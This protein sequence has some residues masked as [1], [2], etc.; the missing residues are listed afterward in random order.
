L[1]STSKELLVRRAPCSDDEIQDSLAH[2]HGGV[3]LS[4]P[5]VMG[6]KELELDELFEIVH[7]DWRDLLEVHVR[8]SDAINWPDLS[9]SLPSLGQSSLFALGGRVH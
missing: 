3:G 8:E 1:N 6:T 4:A 9:L 2:L 5:L 7:Q